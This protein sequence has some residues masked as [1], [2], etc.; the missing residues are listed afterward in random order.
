MASLEESAALPATLSSLGT[1]SAV[2][3]WLHLLE[4]LPPHEVVVV[5][6]WSLSRV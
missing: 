4:C 5:I 3:L 1:V 2:Q 6:V